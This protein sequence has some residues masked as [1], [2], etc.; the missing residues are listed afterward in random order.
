MQTQMNNHSHWLCLTTDS[1]ENMNEIAFARAK[2]C[3]CGCLKPEIRYFLNIL[4][5]VFDEFLLDN[6]ILSLLSSVLALQNTL[7]A[8]A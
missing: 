7:S 4:F 8:A 3:Y 1:M 5:S 6:S 2:F